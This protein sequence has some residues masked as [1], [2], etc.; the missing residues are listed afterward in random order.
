MKSKGFT[1][2]ELLVVVAIIGVLATIVLS[3]LNSARAKARDAKRLQNIK[4]IQT[5]FELYYLD[6]GSY[7]STNSIGGGQPNSPNDHWANSAYSSWDN[8]EAIMGVD[9]P[10]DPV[11]NVTVSWPGGNTNAFQ[12]S[13]FT[14][15]PGCGGYGSSYI[16]VAQLETRNPT[17]SENPGVKQ[18]SSG[19][20]KY[21]AGSINVGFSPVQ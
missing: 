16:I 1:L 17:D 19:V 13:I 11:N 20:L 2:I 15:I 7:P 6:N 14:S 8:L 10:E 4:T 5:A 9:L 12:Y 3:S 18:C 21:G